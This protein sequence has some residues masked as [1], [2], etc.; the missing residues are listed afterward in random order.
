MLALLLKLMTRVKVGLS[1]CIRYSVGM[2][3][4]VF[5]LPKEIQFQITILAQ[6]LIEVP[7]RKVV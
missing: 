7:Q 1:H 4:L 2:Q 5:F 6:A 3:T